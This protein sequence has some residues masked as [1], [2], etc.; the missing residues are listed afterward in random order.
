M[1]RLFPPGAIR[2]QASQKLE[3]GPRLPGLFAR[4]PGHAQ[5]AALKRSA[6]RPDT[7]PLGVTAAQ[8]VLAAELSGRSEASDALS[9]MMNSMVRMVQAGQSQDSRWSDGGSADRQTGGSSSGN[10]F[11]HWIQP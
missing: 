8:R 1:C 9:M 6:S 11:S 2:P 10:A 5:V 4:I 7:T 3:H